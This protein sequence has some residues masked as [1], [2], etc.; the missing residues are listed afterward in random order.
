LSF[1]V[2]STLAYPLRARLLRVESHKD[3]LHFAALKYVTRVEVTDIGKHSS[4]L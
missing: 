2:T 1:S 3:E 4:L